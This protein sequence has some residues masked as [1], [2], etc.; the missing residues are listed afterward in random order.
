MSN[1]N[2]RGLAKTIEETIEQG[3]WKR[4]RFNLDNSEEISSMIVF[5]IAI[6]CNGSQ[7]YLCLP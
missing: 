7:F 2:Y 4:S 1:K 5:T 6:C 3:N